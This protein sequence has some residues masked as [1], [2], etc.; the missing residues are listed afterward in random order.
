MMQLKRVAI[1]K[2]KI[3]LPSQKQKKID[4]FGKN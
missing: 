3:V 2:Q 1:K 4:N